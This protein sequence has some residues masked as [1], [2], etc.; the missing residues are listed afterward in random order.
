MGKKTVGYATAALLV[1]GAAF[2]IAPRPEL[3]AGLLALGAGCWFLIRLDGW[4]RFYV[5]TLI[6]MMGATSNI[7]P[8][9]AVSNYGRYAAAAALLGVTWFTT[10]KTASVIRSRLHKR[11]LGMLWFTV[12]LAAASIVWSVD[13]M[14][15]VLQVVALSVL[16]GLIHLLSTR[17]WVDRALMVR[18]FAVMFNVMTV[19][20]IACLAAW[21][22][23]LP[24]AV[25]YGGTA[26]TGGRFQG[27][28]NNP[29]MLA[30]LLAVS[31]PI[32]IGLIRERRSIPAV[33]GLL[34]AGA[35]LLLTES[36]TAI[37][38][39]AIAIVWLILRSG[40]LAVA[41]FAYA[42]LIALVVVLATG[43]DLFGTSLSRFGTL[44][45]GDVL[46]TRGEAW[47]A[48]ISLIQQQPLG[49]GW[50]AGRQ[51]FESMHGTA[52]F[53]FTR[54]S[55]HNSY[56]QFILELGVIG[57]LPIAYLSMAL[58]LITV[59]GKMRG[60]EAGL[61]GAATAGFIV[62]ITES[63]IFGSGQAYPYVFWFAVAGALTVYLPT[64]KKERAKTNGLPS[65]YQRL[66]RR[67]E[68]VS[69]D[70]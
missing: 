54:T 14:Q 55:V 1:F 45:G 23:R 42:S 44:E 33:A 60:L 35:V 32:G 5:L 3:A 41:K 58:I 36:R 7:G 2:F 53:T 61:V 66:A 67:R 11:T 48:A 24:G 19:A 26:D 65:H 29:N 30:V 21:A 6:L 31:I 52:G 40:A 22:L 17:R 34:T 47:T 39:T 43:L 4:Q 50:Q 15:T 63:V 25:A 28:F 9:V 57:I 13:R 68:K 56:L 46:N 59:R 12:A 64:V 18:D 20:F 69:A 27:F 8:L 10:R 49:Y 70:A 62:Q 51:L 37:V 16:V 38:A